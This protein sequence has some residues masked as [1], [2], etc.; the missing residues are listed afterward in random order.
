MRVGR[1]LDSTLS[2][3]T[4]GAATRRLPAEEDD[5]E[6]STKLARLPANVKFPA[7]LQGRV[8]FDSAA[9]QLTYRGFMTKCTYDELC[10]LSEDV[11]YHRALEQL[12]IQTSGEVAPHRSHVMPAVI[13]L[14][15]VFAALLIVL[16]LWIVANRRI[17]VPQ[18]SPADVT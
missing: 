17:G 8:S 5:M 3:L 16:V 9:G 10:A 15:S 14:A 2:G 4:V 18:A 1:R 11:E 12:F 7:R 13:G 6:Y